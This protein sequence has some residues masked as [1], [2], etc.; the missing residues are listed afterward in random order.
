MGYI[1]ESTYSKVNLITLYY[2]SNLKD[3]NKWA[4]FLQNKYHVDTEI[5]TE[6]E[7]MKLHPEKFLIE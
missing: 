3:A 6:N 1:V 5:Y 4:D 7:Y 2:K